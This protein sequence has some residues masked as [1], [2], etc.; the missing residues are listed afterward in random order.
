MHDVGVMSLFIC[1]WIRK[2]G[3]GSVCVCV[4]VC[5]CLCILIGVISDYT[6][7]VKS[8]VLRGGGQH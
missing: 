2:V 8:L 3:S 1:C 5:V 6:V 4:C 7:D